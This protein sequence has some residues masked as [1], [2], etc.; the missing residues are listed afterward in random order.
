MA[1]YSFTTI[2]RIAAPVEKI[3]DVI[4][5]SEKYPTWWK[6]VVKVETLS[7]G[8]ANGI[9]TVTRTTWKTHLP[10]GF[11]FDTRA[12]RIEPFKTLEL[13]AFGDLLGKGLW[14]LTRE[15]D[16]TLV[17]YDWQ[18]KTA[19]LWM[20]LVAPVAAPFFRWNHAAVM[21]DGADGLARL[22]N[23]R[24]LVARAQ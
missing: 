9:G 1:E 3:W 22:L 18:V 13:E 17:Q 11:S 2:W 7:R 19:K 20:N 16:Q 23:T 4:I 12:V 21:N 8:D 10:Y 24:V 14:T 6:S 5:E 15:G